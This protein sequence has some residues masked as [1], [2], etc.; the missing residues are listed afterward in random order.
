MWFLDQL[1][2]GSSFYNVPTAVR[3]EGALDVAALERALHEL[4]RRHEALRT[5]FHI[6]QG[7]PVQVI[8]ADGSLPLQVEDLRSLPS[9]ERE[10]EARRRTT[11][12]A[13]R[14]FDLG[15]GPVLRA[16]LLRLDEQQHVLVLTLHHIVSD[17][18]S[19]GVLVREVAAL[20]EAFSQ[21]R[22]S[23]LTELPVQYAD[24]SAWQRGWL[25][26]EVLEQQ[27]GWWRQQ[28][29][30][31]PRALELPTDKP[32]PPV[33]TYRGATRRIQLPPELSQ[34]IKSLARQEGVTPFML[35]LAAFQVL[36][37]RYSG[38]DDISVG[39]P[40][41]GRNRG[42]VEGLI[43]FFVNTLV[44]R[45]RLSPQRSFRELLARVKE[46]TLGA[47]AHQELPFEKLVEELQP[48]R[49]MSRSPL[50]QVLFT[51]QNAPMSEQSLPGLTMRP[52]ELPGDTAKFDLS[53]GMMEA[54]QGF[55]GDLEYN[56]DLYESS[57]IQRMLGHLHVL[58]EGIAAAPERQVRELPLL[59]DSE[60][61]Q[62][63]VDWNAT[64]VNYPRES[65]VPSLF[66]AQVER[67]P[68]SIAVEYQGQTLTYRQLNSRSNQLAHHLRQLGVGPEVRVGLCLE[69]S[70]EL[71][72]AI[73]GVLKAGGT[74]VPFDP[75]YPADRLSFML[76]DTGV[77][78]ILTQSHLANALP[79]RDA[80][81]IRLDADWE[82][83]RAHP[84]SNPSSG[85]S[86]DNTAYI[87][88]T[89]GSTGRPKGVCVPHR[90]VVRL[91]QGSTFIDMGPQEVFLQLAPISFDA[92]TLELWGALLH[93]AK[94]VV[95]PAGT[96]SLDELGTALVRSGITTLWLTAALFEQMQATQPH[97]LRGVRQ[98]LA[99][100]DVLP[101]GRVKERLSHGGLLVNGYGPTENTTFT[102]C[103]PMSEVSQV[104]HTVSIGTPISNT[105][106]YLLD[107][108][109]QPVPA[110]VA[111]E[112][113]T[114]GDGLA[115][116]YLNRPE[117][118]A[119]KFVPNPFSSEPGGRLYRTGD[120]AR[121]LPDG[122]IEFLG[123]IDNQVKVRG[124]RI[125]LGEVESVLA[126]NPQVRETVVVVREDVPGDKRLVAYV[127]ANDAI[128]EAS[129]LRAWMKQRL[130]EYMVP[131]AFVVLDTLPLS[132]NGKVDRKALP[133]PE[134]PAASQEYVA[135]RNETEERLA[136]LWS[137]VLRMPRVGIHDNFFEL[138]GHSL[139][140]TQVVARIRESF[141]VELPL[142]ELF[143]APTLAGLAMRI[144]ASRGTALSRAP[145]LTRVSREGSLP[146]SFSQ[147]RLW[148][149][150][151]LQP[152]GAFY[153][154]PMLVRLEG[155]LDVAAL[156]RSF[157]ELLQRHE[158]LRTTFGQDADG[159]PVQLIAPQG[160]MPL[161][162]VELQSLP[163]SER[164]AELRR[165]AAEDAMKPFDLSRGP[166]LRALLLRQEAQNHVLLLT[167]HHIISDG[168]SMGVLVREMGALYEAFSQG[169]PSP[170]P[171]L[172]VQ[173]ADYSA[174]QRGW[175]QGEVLEEQ[176]G[177]W[178]QQLA[179]APHALELPTDKP[180]PPVQTHRGATLRT[181]LPFPL[182]RA[183][184]SLALKEGATPFMLLLAAF[185]V[186]MSRYSG[187]DDIS[188]G[189][190][191]A[192]RNRGGVEGL[193]GFFVNTLILRSQLSPQRSFRE[194][195][196]SVRET[197]LGAYAHQEM[198]F[199]KLVEA[200]QP[201]RD[202][203]RSPLFQVMFT[204]QNAPMPEQ[205]LPGLTLRPMELPG[206][207]A[208]FDLSLGFMET[209]QGFAGELEYNTDLYEAPT[210]Q[211]MLGH[212]HVLLEGI[213]ATPELELWQLSL[214]GEAERRQ[215]LVDWSEP[216][217]QPVGDTCLHHLVEAQV[218]R[219]P[220]AVA[221]IS[222][223]RRLTY[224][225]LERRSNQ[226]AARLRQLGVGPEVKVGVCLER[227]ELL[228]IA[229]LGVL[230]AGG[231]YVPLDP[232]YPSDRLGY[233]LQHTGVP[234]LLT[235]QR[236][237]GSLPEHPA[238]VLM[239]D[240][241]QAQLD[242]L[243]AGRSRAPVHPSNLAYVLYTSGSTGRPKGVSLEHRNSV[244]F[245]HW[246]LGVFSREQLSGVL[247]A[248]SL[249]FDLSVF[250]LFAPLSR[251]GAVIVAE[252]ALALPTLEARDEVTLVNTVPSAMAELVRGQGVP[253]S[254]R[255]VNLAGEPLTGA[256]AR[257]IHE[258]PHVEALYNLYGPTEDTTYSTFVRVPRDSQR[259]PTIGKPLAGTQGYVLDAS[260]QLVP[261]GVPGELYLG[262]AGLARGYLYRPELAAERFVPNPFSSTPGER[263]YR[264]GD[265]VRYLPDG[266]LEYLGRIDNQVKVRGFR[267][268]LG[269]IETALRAHPGVRDVVVV[270]REDSPGD[271]RLVAYLVAQ[272]GHTLVAMELRAF[273][274]QS[275]PEYMVPSALMVLD[276]LPLNPNGKVDRKALPVPDQLQ[277]SQEYVAPRNE[278]EQMLAQLWSEVLKAP[279]IGAHDNFFELGGHSLLATQLR[280]RIRTAF[281]VELPLRD[282]FEAPT[283]A[284]LAGRLDAAIRSGQGVQTPP[285]VRVSREGALPLSFAQQR[286]WFLDQL[287]PGN[288]FYNVPTAVRL[289]GE[290]DVVAL[291]KSLTELV[292]RHES[293]RTT[294]QFQQNEPVQVIS[295][296][297]SLTLEKVE[298]QPL[299]PAEL[300]AEVRKI[301]T[302]HAMRPFDLQRGPLLRALLVRLSEQQHVL[303]VTLHH[304]ISDG[305]SMG[306]LVREVA[307]L[308]QAFN[309]GKP[310]PLPELPVQYADYAAW[311]RGWLQGEV[312]EKQLG[313]WRQ[314]LEGAPRALEMPTDRPR[315]PVMTLRGAAQ[316]VVFPAELSRA[317]L[318][319]CK[320]EGVTPF[321]LLLAAFQVLLSRYSG[322]DDISVGSP[323][324]G[325]TRTEVESLIGFFVNTLVLRSRL[326]PQQSF[327]ALLA[328]VRETT[329]GAYAHQELPFEKLV[330]ELH[331][332]RDLSRTPLFQVMLTFQNTPVQALESPGMKLS[333]LEV[334]T[335]TARFEMGL[336][337]AEEA[338]ALAGVLRY[339]A[340]LYEARTAAR[341][342]GH[343]RVLLEGAVADPERSLGL[344]SLLS[345]AER[346]QM[347]VEWNE[348]RRDF[349]FEPSLTAAF[350]AQVARTPDA[351]ALLFEGS[352][353]TFRELNQRANQL[354]H[355][356]RARGIGPNVLVAMCL[357]RSLEQV[358]AVFGIL[359]AGGAY[360]PLD[361]NYPQERLALVLEDSRA[362]VLLTQQHLLSRLQ[363]PS[364]QVI[365]LD[366][367][368]EQI[369]RESVENPPHVNGP[370]DLAYVIYTSGSTGVP[371][372][373]MIQQGSVLNLRHA[374]ACTVYADVQAPQRVSL[375]APLSFDASVKQ[376]VRILDG[377]ALCMVPDQARGDVDALLA[378]LARDQVD[379]LDCS[380]SHLRLLLSAGLATRTENVPTRVLVG[381]EALD[382]ALWTTLSQH[383]RTRFFNVYG[384]TEC[385][386]DTTACEVRDWPRPTLGRVL[387]NVRGYVLDARMQPVPV[388]VPGELYV[389]GAGVARGYL[390]RPELT[391]QK[392]VADPFSQQPGARLYRTGDLV[393]YLPDG[394]IDYLGR[395]DFQVKVR[396]FRIELEEIE[397]VLSSHPSVQQATVVAREDTPGD[398]R[399]VAYLVAREGQTFDLTELRG[400]LRKKLPEYMV[401]SAFVALEKLP[402][403]SSG[404]V[405]RKA[406]P[407]P[408]QGR[409]EVAGAFVPPRD[410][411]ELQIARIWEDVLG[412]H[413]VGAHSNFFDLG[414][415]SLLAVRLMGRLREVTGRTLPLAAL[416]QAPTVE[417]LA[418]LLRSEQR[419]WTPLVPLVPREKDDPRR[420]L[421]VVHPVGG[422]VIG[423][424]ELA[425]QLG[426]KQ[427]VYALE[428]QGMDGSL[429][430][431]KTIEEMAAL[432]V[433]AIRTLQP[434]GPYLL[435]GWSMGGVIAY[436]MAQQ[437]LRQGEQVEVL[438]LIDS[439]VPN[440]RPAH[441]TNEEEALKQ[442]FVGL[443]EE[444]VGNGFKVPEELVK[445]LDREELLQVIMETAR[446]TNLAL[447]DVGIEQVRGL[448]D[449]FE[450]NLRASWYYKPTTY[451]GE[452]FT[453]LRAAK[454]AEGQTED[455]GWA[456]LVPPSGRLDI[457]EVPGAHFEL[458][459]QPYVQSVAERLRE[460]LERAHERQATEI[461][462]TP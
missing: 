32:R 60:R 188:V 124:F 233:M 117:L 140:A 246:A 34:S 335:Q 208:K 316:P 189:S 310:S 241:A 137:E 228:V 220:D 301:T 97:A 374:L 405:D 139:L 150:E 332:E 17:G 1:Q 321:M 118:T 30:D 42:E 317:L 445:S 35:L 61:R 187:Q 174:W 50:F 398:K 263:L 129:D 186:L 314:Q 14:P 304:I 177:W 353:L 176:L 58:L 307:A 342:V 145:A 388:G 191:I 72:I 311:Q 107:A 11:A 399:L 303:V 232:A 376:L 443:V 456:A 438:M 200:L 211:R 431:L 306:V 408:D 247:A 182:S 157:E 302:E 370:E 201:E 202:L 204:V 225:E 4:V 169:R 183:L 280:S 23:P 324:A 451:V 283:V 69:R 148:F 239:L 350:E 25:Q 287:Q 171:E 46:T 37:S 207:T 143:D 272:P 133:V 219:T 21:G 346:R 172:P 249:N 26:G 47:Y 256:L 315:P 87:M 309:Q 415:H 160:V 261:V 432:Y 457:H 229:V 223:T 199:E 77:K 165:L 291:E 96:P 141:Q 329:L 459:K 78:V 81:F 347:L 396:G 402:L 65:T 365:C 300:E 175:L 101:V 59:N 299:P 429:P 134:Q 372:G 76:Q 298:A 192:G 121:Y 170:L 423:Y 276:K 24:Y 7:Q 142:R 82:Q 274:K 85:P 412:V 382:E 206:D 147:Q 154:I 449:V 339:N 75:S 413:P 67:S 113:Y 120:L 64:R 104:G 397:A 255:T 358:V 386:V 244:A 328:Q 453:L 393:R 422:T 338:G 184:K 15:R 373:V 80:L 419:A 366:T 131:S 197:T 375:N 63:L 88:Y 226:L 185:Q 33:Q 209:E 275:L 326:S 357:E 385:T 158:S 292:R 93:G 180:R 95:Y 269:E 411:L 5:T 99:G 277:T 279:R 149:L 361:P 455:R 416:F 179:G 161:R 383:P 450:A 273:L 19:M 110:G 43:G 53:L 343:L 325:R 308:Y 461:Q 79:A 442:A 319:L 253:T 164:E 36:L 132:P 330:E 29:A 153:N 407:A 267:I 242:S 238:H 194:L 371:K 424:S 22:P 102:C 345:D 378:L 130:P 122:R 108:W 9:A 6:H 395:V 462:R 210:L 417:K 377:H 271:K 262:G 435:G 331:P 433:E 135:P 181:Q 286:L 178:R 282:L 458:L 406:L 71:V 245:I 421:F 115:S 384:P 10:A 215:L 323:I 369:A 394:S 420:P 48:E 334:D 62:L 114:G 379:V 52:L 227:S 146:L 297:S 167:M 460:Y 214:L 434:S 243:P 216:L 3:L 203:S 39:S 289:E 258:L 28:L 111:G 389:G 235:Q 403:N 68:D 49:D 12:H 444:F 224:R 348:T 270:A 103:Y 91:V 173:Y 159:Q 31:A 392:F 51:V 320:R 355:L 313:W 409:I 288:S 410:A 84:E 284:T 278:T 295:P 446:Q 251:G 109:M 98:L 285:L 41:A 240:E 252:N 367:D 327:R 213:A 336:T 222:G 195:L 312:L 125:E 217:P 363:A 257:L 45:T 116:G 425:R 106:V 439:Q 441:V 391:S 156:E 16:L 401:P 168:W 387:P 73:L 293:L 13:L 162:V 230:K 333:P 40:I 83:V 57:T 290:L 362:P 127:V 368:A 234:V 38:Q 352:R 264:T 90:G 193:I 381:G 437:L 440:G 260:M 236:A 94:L 166:L 20:Y 281:Q 296:D 196:A 151:Q 340:D 268:E 414:G 354:A 86:A 237:A 254:V 155:Q 359:K 205:S 356:L 428:S 322:Q 447:P 126:Q 144:D 105:Q 27:L 56:T 380:P 89:S 55:L 452:Q 400:A 305:W 128:P 100:G 66:E 266:Q 70:L 2:P 294:F 119:E 138:G 8:S 163:P 152:S 341:L 54:D 390:R 448:R 198:P 404:K 212:L 190:P 318:E 351:L 44:L 337:F 344:L 426:P 250:E 136:A 436:E 430:P 18:W 418:Q 364:A 259:E 360:V 248:T 218:D 454:A 221:V 123:R 265:R 112:L 74:Y 92:S 427:P 231:T 349:P